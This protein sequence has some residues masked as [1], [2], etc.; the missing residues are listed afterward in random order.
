[1]TITDDSGESSPY[2]GTISGL[3]LISG[4]GIQHTEG[5]CTY[6]NGAVQG[7]LSSSGNTRMLNFTEAYNV[8]CVDPSCSGTERYRWIVTL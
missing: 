4:T 5:R 2:S 1:M 7:T 8:S 3:G 6:S